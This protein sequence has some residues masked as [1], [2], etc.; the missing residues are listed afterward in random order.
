VSSLTSPGR[1]RSGSLVRKGEVVHLFRLRAAGPV[2]VA[3]DRPLG[4]DLGGRRKTLTWST[5]MPR[6]NW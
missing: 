6:C 3:A 5:S 2:R 4:H 1:Q